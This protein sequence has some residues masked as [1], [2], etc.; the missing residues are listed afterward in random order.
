[1]PF[2]EDGNINNEIDLNEKV[3]Y[4]VV[5]CKITHARNLHEVSFIYLAKLL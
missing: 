2:N 4:T 3:L 1:M 5:W